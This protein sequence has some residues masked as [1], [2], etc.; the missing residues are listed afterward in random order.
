MTPIASNMSYDIS[1]LMAQTRK[2]ASDYRNET[3]QA[4]PVTEEL[5]RFDGVTLLKLK[6]IEGHEGV[7]AVS[8]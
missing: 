1:L 5:A 3:G 2:L 4:L 8:T 6:K 7:D